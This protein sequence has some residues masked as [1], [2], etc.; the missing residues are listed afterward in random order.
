MEKY[1]LDNLFFIVTAFDSHHTKPWRILS[2]WDYQLT[3]PHFLK[4][5][6]LLSKTTVNGS[7]AD[8]ILIPGLTCTRLEKTDI[9]LAQL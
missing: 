7:N 1:V 6:N 4:Y 9:T 8:Q 5:Y 3:I 2:L